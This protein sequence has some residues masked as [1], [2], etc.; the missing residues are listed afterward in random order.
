M[1]ETAEEG[2]AREIREETGLV[3]L[4]MSYLFSLPNRYVYSGM[5]IHTLDMF[6][7]VEVAD[8]AVPVA[9]DDAASLTW[10]PLSEVRPEDFGLQSISH[11]VARFLQTHNYL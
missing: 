2:M 9:D 7:R 1:D 8:D 3:A 10:L 6:F 5:T 11:A 4:R